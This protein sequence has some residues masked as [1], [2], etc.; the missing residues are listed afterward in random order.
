M[1]D[2]MGTRIREVR[3]DKGLTLRK[4]AAELGIPPSYLSDIENS[5]RLPSEKVMKRITEVLGIPG[6]ELQLLDGRIDPDLKRWAEGQPKVR[7]LLR[8]M[9]DQNV[10]MDDV[11]RKL[12]RLLDDGD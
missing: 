2:T 10:D 1:N 12:S 9:K 6:S 8:K 11:E 3:K 5:R 4:A 7:H